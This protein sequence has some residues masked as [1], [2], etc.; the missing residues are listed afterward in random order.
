MDPL[1]TLNWLLQVILSLL[2]QVNAAL[3]IFFF[4]FLRSWISQKSLGEVS[5][6][7]LAQAPQRTQ[8]LSSREL[9]REGSAVQHC[10]VALA[11]YCLFRSYKPQGSIVLD[12]PAFCS[13]G[14]K[15]RRAE[16][17]NGVYTASELNSWLVRRLKSLI[18]S[19]G[20]HLT[21]TLC[22]VVGAP[23]SETRDVVL[24]R[25]ARGGWVE[26]AVGERM[27]NRKATFLL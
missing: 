20:R 9:G 4:F 21:S 25:C 13:S 19:L 18:Y 11:L 7:E 14:Y 23:G 10:Q 12:F 17:M 27:E 5:H 24:R 15:K 16:L 6:T 3:G 22:Q 8:A 1:L 2:P 26:G